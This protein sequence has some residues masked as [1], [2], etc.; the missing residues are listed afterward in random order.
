[1]KY[2]RSEFVA[3]HFETAIEFINNPNLDEVDTDCF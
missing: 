2:T 3:F 1:M